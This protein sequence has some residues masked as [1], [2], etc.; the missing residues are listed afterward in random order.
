MKV[1][2]VARW[3]ILAALVTVLFLLLKQPSRLNTEQQAP[4]TVTANAASFQDKLGELQSAHENGE[5]GA[6]VRLSSDEVSA[7]LAVANPSPSASPVGSPAPQ[8]IS[9][10]SS[11]GNLNNSTSLT[12]EQ[13]PVKN[14]QVMF[15][16]D[17][18]KGQF[19]ANVYGKDVFV[20]LA[21][22]LGASDGYVT[23]QPTSFTI[24]NMPVPISLVQQQLDK[25]FSEPE[26]REKLKLPDFVSD[27]RVENGQ[28]VI[29][30]K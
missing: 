19:A 5:Q 4:A 12:P 25:K 16:G 21:G 13:V 11:D 9:T 8:P 26:T 14:P 22:H 28:L 30:E 29:V 20:T 27:L 1:Y 18:V 6:E 2:K 23:F 10:P 7:A 17:Q 24:G 15:E 3:V